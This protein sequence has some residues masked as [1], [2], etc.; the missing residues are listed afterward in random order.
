MAESAYDAAKVAAAVKAF[1]TNDLTPVEE[2]LAAG[3]VA[4]ESMAK[5]RNAAKEFRE[6]VGDAETAAFARLELNDLISELQD[7]VPPL[8]RCYNSLL[9][10]KDQEGGPPES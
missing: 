3:C 10:E 1:Q 6:R 7:A 9:R 4:L 2:M 5:F 8:I